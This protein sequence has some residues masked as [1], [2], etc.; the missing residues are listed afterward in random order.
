[1]SN[2]LRACGWTGLLAAGLLAGCG[3]PGVPLPPSLNLPEPVKNLTA[4]RAGSQVTLAWTM[5]T[6]TT[7]RLLLKDAIT[8][9]VCRHAD[10]AENCMETGLLAPGAQGSYVDTLPAALAAGAPRPLEY[11]VELRNAKGRSAGFSNGAAV[12]AGQAPPA[13]AGLTAEVRKAGVVL[14]WTPAPGN[15]ATEVRLER[16]LLT[17][18]VPHTQQGPMAAPPQPLEQNLLV[19][20]KVLDGRALDKTI[21]FGQ[22]YAYRAQRVA[23][24]KA[25]DEW[26]A[27]DG[28]FSAPVTVEARDVFPPAVP[29]GLA[30]VAVTGQNAGI[31]L[32][33]QPDTEPDVAGYRVYRREG[34]GAW[35]RISDAQP[36]AAPAYHDATAEAG[37]AYL[38]AVTAV[39]QNGHESARSG[40]AQETMPNP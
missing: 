35:T 28:P 6:R 15:G 26:L 24:V 9:R 25:G 11:R 10:A 14:H 33:W 38:Y 4:T 29:T 16:K 40:D 7:D 39:G 3:M 12:L 27:L 13:V 2:A 20:T 30:A 1:M 37:H 5:P 19:A 34:D 23:R 36:V 8:V 18:P 21:Q 31:D 32:S 22:T 17:P